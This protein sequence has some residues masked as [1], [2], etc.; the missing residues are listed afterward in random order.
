VAETLP[1]YRIVRFAA[2]ALQITRQ[3]WPNSSLDLFEGPHLSLAHPLVGGTELCRKLLDDDRAL[4]QA[5]RLE[6]QH[7][8]PPLP[9][10]PSALS[11]P[12]AKSRAVRN[13][14]SSTEP[15]I[16]PFRR[17]V[18]WCNI[19]PLVC[20][21]LRSRH[22]VP[23]KAIAKTTRLRSSQPCCSLVCGSRYPPRDRSHPQSARGSRSPGDMV[24]RSLARFGQR[25]PPACR[26]PRDPYR[27]PPVTRLHA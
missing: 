3:K 1:D 24:R 9:D 12:D 6:P 4:T 23:V 8:V 16:S 20:G 27:V 11:N 14:A 2:P 15:T 26:G 22:S 5:A 19:V 7:M 13:P 21:V 25:P 10:V 17:R 18:T